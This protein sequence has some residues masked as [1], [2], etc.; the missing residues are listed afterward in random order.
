MIEVMPFTFRICCFTVA[1]YLF[2]R[3]SSLARVL[4]ASVLTITH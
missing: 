1:A 2:T 3:I 4:F